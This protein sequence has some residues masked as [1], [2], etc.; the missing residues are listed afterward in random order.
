MV[1]LLPLTPIVAAPVPQIPRLGTM[2]IFPAEWEQEQYPLDEKSSLYSLSSICDTC[3]TKIQ[4]VSFKK[5]GCPKV[6]RV[7]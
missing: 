3:C 1:S 2:I 6:E 4:F 7:T 5:N